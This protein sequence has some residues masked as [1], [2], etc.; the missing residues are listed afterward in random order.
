MNINE[1]L[2]DKT[3]KAKDKTEALS[4]LLLDK[5]ISADELV[6]FAETANDS[7]KATCIEAI[8]FA[9]KQQPAIL[10][11]K[12]FQFV[13]Q[14]LA[15]DAPKVKWE[16]AR[17]IGNTVHIFSHKLEDAIKYLL[18]NSE[19]SGTVVRWSA[20]FALAQILKLQTKHNKE[21]LPAIEAIINREEKDSI[22]KIYLAAVKSCK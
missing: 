9:T 3:T 15:S 19:H 17:V 16:S 18:E 7:Q 22:K 8:E 20:A 1:I 6:T 5:T 12:S 13:T 2:N 21:L 14:S 4:K 10:K 11:I